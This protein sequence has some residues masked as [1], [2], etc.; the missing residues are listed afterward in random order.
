MENN[1]TANSARPALFFTRS[2]AAN[3]ASNVLGVIV[4]IGLTFGISYL[5]QR[6]KLKYN[7]SNF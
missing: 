3:F 5:V 7:Y 2:W 6:H 4:G 1:S